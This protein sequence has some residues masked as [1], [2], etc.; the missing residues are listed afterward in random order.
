MTTD[1]ATE[2]RATALGVADRLRANSD[3]LRSTAVRNAGQHPEVARAIADTA[4][5]LLL[6]AD[7]LV[8]LVD[9]LRSADGQQ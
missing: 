5:H 7:A 9:A 6:T 1:E 3:V 4:E 8:H 2:I